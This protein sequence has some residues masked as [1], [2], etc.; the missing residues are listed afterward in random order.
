[1]EVRDVPLADG[2]VI[3][4]QLSGHPD[5]PAMVLLHALGEQAATWDEVAARFTTRFRIVALDLRGHGASTWHDRPR[6]P[7]PNVPAESLP[8][9][10]ARR[11]P[12]LLHR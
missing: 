9:P 3:S 10:V 11:T 7:A 12:V 2:L 8:P 6:D 5:S 1:V 4:C